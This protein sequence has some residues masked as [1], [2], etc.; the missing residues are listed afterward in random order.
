MPTLEPWEDSPQRAAYYIAWNMD[1]SPAIGSP[2]AGQRRA[3]LAKQGVPAS[4]RAIIKFYTR[5]RGRRRDW[6]GF[7]Y[8]YGGRP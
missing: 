1:F 7:P 8:T 3:W 4:E 6:D 2:T 5:H